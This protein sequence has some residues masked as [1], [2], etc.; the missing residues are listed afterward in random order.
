MRHGAR[1]L[2][3]GSDFPLFLLNDLVVDVRKAPT[4]GKLGGRRLSALSFEAVIRLGQEF[5]AE[6]PLLHRTQPQ[7]AERLAALLAAKGKGFNAALFIAPS[8]ECLPAEV[9]VRF[10]AVPARV[11]GVLHQRQDAGGLDVVA[12]DRKVWKR[13]AA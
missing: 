9:V 3:T 8:L 11:M 2:T 1:V 7:M 6:H 4:P 12:A 10:T 13:F 5:Y